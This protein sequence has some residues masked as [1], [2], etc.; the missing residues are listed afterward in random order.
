MLAATFVSPTSEGILCR[1]MPSCTNFLRPTDPDI[2]RLAHLQLVDIG[3]DLYPQLRRI[4]DL[5]RCHRSRARHR[6]T[7]S[8]IP[9][10]S[11]PAGRSEQEVPAAGCLLVGLLVSCAAGSTGQ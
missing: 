6:H 5:I 3:Q 2:F 10:H 1:I 4:P 7:V 9:G 11:Q 8:S